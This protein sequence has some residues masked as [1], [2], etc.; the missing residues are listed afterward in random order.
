MIKQFNFYDIYGYLL[1]GVLLLGILWLPVG[2]LTRS[3]PDQDISKALFLAALAYI[4]GHL[5]QLVSN[6]LVP[7]TVPDEARR[8]RVRSEF[9]LDK[10]NTQFSADFKRRLA[11]Q[12][13]K[14]FGLSVAVDRDSDG[15]DEIS[16][17]RQAAFF[18]ARS[19][20]IAKKAAN[21]AEQFEGLYAMMRGLGCSFCAGVAY[22]VGWCL[23]FHRGRI[24]LSTPIAVLFAIAIIGTLISVWWAKS[25]EYVL[26]M[27]CQWLAVFLGIGFWAN[28][29]H[30]SNSWPNAPAHTEA[31]FLASGAVALI[32]A[33]KCLSSYRSFADL[34]AKTVWRDFSAC[35][36]YQEVP[37]QTSDTSPE[38]ASEES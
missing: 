5:V 21:Y 2:V 18:Q 3:W 1:P 15:N 24:C 14:L 8:P 22:Y 25:V 33:A 32:A 10:S 29:S 31:I 30:P 26:W 20:L 34:F 17:N 23:A 6:P 9:L 16:R 35:L 13:T 38:G 12:V 37:A 11:G 36:S 7:S 27:R 19:Y 4:V 28:A